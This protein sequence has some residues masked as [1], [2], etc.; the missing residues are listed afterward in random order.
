MKKILLILSTSLLI[1]ACGKNVS[2]GQGTNTV[3]YERS[4]LVNAYEIQ[5]ASMVQTETFVIGDVNIYRDALGLVATN[6][7]GGATNGK[8]DWV[9]DIVIS[10]LKLSSYLTID[11]YNDGASLA[12]NLV[13]CQLFFTYYPIDNSGEKKVVLANFVEYNTAKKQVVLQ[14]INDD[15]TTLFKEQVFGGR[16]ELVFRFA[17]TPHSV[18]KMN[19]RYKL[20]F[21]FAYTFVSKEAKK[22]E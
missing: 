5:T 14:P 7:L 4:Y 13:N 20:P 18:G 1:A 11:L 16:L 12:S 22:K 2:K 6:A 21:D 9:K 19:L 10:N 17:Q 15:L 3:I 8:P